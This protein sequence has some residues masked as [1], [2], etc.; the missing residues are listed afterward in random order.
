MVGYRM[1]L[2][3]SVL[4]CPHRRPGQPRPIS[5]SSP[6][7]SVDAVDALDQGAERRRQVRF[8][9]EAFGV[10]HDL[11]HGPRQQGVA[12][13]DGVIDGG[14]VAHVTVARAVLAGRVGLGTRS[15]RAIRSNI[16]GSVKWCSDS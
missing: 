8:G 15:I 6:R 12:V 4:Y 3:H 5:G 9:C 16:S 14:A 7:A 13:F 2:P 10:G 11:A 1:P